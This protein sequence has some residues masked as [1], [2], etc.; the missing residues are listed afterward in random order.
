MHK[1]YKKIEGKAMLPVSMPC[2]IIYPSTKWYFSYVALNDPFFSI[3]VRLVE[4]EREEKMYWIST[5]DA[6][7]LIKITWTFFYFIQI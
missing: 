2:N 3:K 5:T 1:I 7:T 6:D 4:E